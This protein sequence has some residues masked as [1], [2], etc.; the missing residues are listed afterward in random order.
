LVLLGLEVI[1][2][3]TESQMSSSDSESDF[4]SDPVSTKSQPRSPKEVIFNHDFGEPTEIVIGMSTNASNHVI[5]PEEE[6][7]CDEGV[8]KHIR[9]SP[10]WDP[11]RI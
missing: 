10:N 11:V 6:E 5:T 4:D 2:E 8:P 9:I 1:H 3:E 7:V